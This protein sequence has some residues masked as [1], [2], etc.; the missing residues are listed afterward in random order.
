MLMSQS[1]ISHPDYPV[2]K[3][4]AEY[5]LKS[6]SELPSRVDNSV[7][8]YFP[9]IL[10]QHGWSC[11]Q[12]SSIGYVMTYEMNRLRDLDS[13]KWN[14]QYAALFPWNFL[15]RCSSSTGVSYFDTWEVVKA[16]GC[17]TMKEFPVFN[18]TNYWMSGYNNYYET[19]KNHVVQ[20]YSIPVATPE[21]L[22]VLKNYL[23]DHMDGSEFGGL[24]NIQIASGGMQFKNTDES[25][26]DPGA[27]ILIG[28]GSVVGHALTVVG[29]DDNVSVDWN[30]DG[31]ITNDIDINGDGKVDMGDWEIGALILANTWGKGWGRQGIAYCSYSV[32]TREGHLGGIWNRSVHVIKAVKEYD[33]V[34]TMKI[35]M[36]HSSRNKFRLLAGI[37][38]DPAATEPEHVMGFAH[39]NYSGNATPLEGDDPQDSTR[40]ELGLDIS[41]FTSYLEPGKE[42]R[43][44]L[45]VNEKDPTD[46]GQGKIRSFSVI[47]YASGDTTEEISESFDTEILNDQTTT[48]SLVRSVDFSKLS[49]LPEEATTVQ[50]GEPFTKQ[51]SVE[52]G[53]APYL[54][55][56][57]EDYEEKHFER[58]FPEITG[59]TLITSDNIK[60]YTWVDLPFVF[61]FY[62]QDH[63]AVVVDKNG[64]L[65][66]NN[67]YYDY[68]YAIDTDLVFKVRRSIIPFGR[69]LKY[70]DANDMI[71]YRAND[72]VAKFIWDA[73]VEYKDEEYN[74]QFAT[75]LYDDGRI[76]F[77][78][79]AFDKPH[80]TIYWWLSGISLGDGR[81]FKYATVSKLGILFENYGACFQPF[82]YPGEVSITDDGL[83][84]CRPAEADKIWNIYVEVHDKN[85][86]LDIGAIPVSTVNW[87]ETEI[88]TQNYPNPFRGITA[89]SFKN[90]IEQEVKLGIYDS[91]GRLVKHLL[92][93]NMLAGEYVYYWNGT[94]VHNRDVGPGVY[95]YRLETPKT[96]TTKKIILIR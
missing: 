93:K 35:V 26:S 14:N 46:K 83:L 55:E 96:Y 74:V 65:H 87:E 27:P 92:S 77:H 79:G 52:G 70:T 42:A 69:N 54:W 45:L 82:K 19:M 40:F 51:L 21:G 81:H 24:A 66:F 9:P 56:L 10:S 6:G 89:I 25:C 73:T 2:L 67:E 90:P 22:L 37:S 57:V 44:F 49:I 1:F 17:A 80:G 12:A 94:N 58:S 39:F 62:G 31:Q 33:P 84:S 63:I 60:Q 61:P 34:I 30:N 32:I 36:D 95:F 75:Y 23:Y 7:T 18:N 47:N 53:E 48:I 13:H 20:N 50:P 4:S 78:Y 68:P 8:K 11:N 91:S 29:Y 28:F 59:D 71:C 88:L 76:E 64:A 5:T 38:T 16:A 15:N 41:R 85:N 3:Q 72:S 43:F 86:Q